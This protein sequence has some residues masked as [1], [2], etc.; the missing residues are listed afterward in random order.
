VQPTAISRGEAFLGKPIW[1]ENINGIVGVWRVLKPNA[2]LTIGKSERQ[3]YA[4]WLAFG[5]P[6]RVKKS[7]LAFRAGEFASKPLEPEYQISL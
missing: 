6:L 7:V 4:I 5:F 1:S 3:S 2:N